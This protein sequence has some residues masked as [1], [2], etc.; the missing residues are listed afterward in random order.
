[1]F[2]Q[3]PD[4]E[5][6]AWIAAAHGWKGRKPRTMPTETADANAGERFEIA[7][8]MGIPLVPATEQARETMKWANDWDAKHLKGKQP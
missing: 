7:G 8:A 6:L 4:Y 1:M 3:P 5:L 2:E